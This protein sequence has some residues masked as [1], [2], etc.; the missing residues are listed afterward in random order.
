MICPKCYNDSVTTVDSR[1]TI[2]T[3]RRRRECPSCFCRF[4]TLELDIRDLEELAG[5][6]EQLL[7]FIRELEIEK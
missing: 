3:V 5:G 6:R 7:Q 2:A 1:P 4:T